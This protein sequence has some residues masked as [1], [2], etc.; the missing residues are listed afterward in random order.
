M[1][2]HNKQFDILDKYSQ[3]T[4]VKAAIHFMKMLKRKKDSIVLLDKK[5]TV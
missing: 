4:I 1:L 2:H 5:S 3:D